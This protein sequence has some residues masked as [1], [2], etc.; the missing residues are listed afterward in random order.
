MALLA[1]QKANHARYGMLGGNGDTHMDTIGQDMPF[2]N[3]T[4]FLTR[5]GMEDRAQLPPDLPIQSSV[6]SSSHRRR[7]TPASVKPLRVALV[8]PVAYPSVQLGVR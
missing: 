6:L 7:T 2:H 1:F 4:L 3:L 5:Q 8:E